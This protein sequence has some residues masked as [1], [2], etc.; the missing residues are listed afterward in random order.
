MKKEK[1][2]EEKTEL[3]DRDIHPEQIIASS[4]GTEPAV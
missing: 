1:N 2:K 3:F 4:K